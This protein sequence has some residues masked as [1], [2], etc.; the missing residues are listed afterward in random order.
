M[1][2]EAPSAR[3]RIG[4]ARR[5]VVGVGAT[6]A[7]AALGYAGSRRMIR[8][9][10]ARP[11]PERGEE[12]AERPGTERHVLSFDV[13][14]LVVNTVGPD[15]GPTLV[16]LHGFSG[17]LTL[18]HYQWKHFS[19]DYRCVLLDH[20]GHGRSGPATGGDYS[21]EA[22]GRDVKAVLDAEAGSGPVALVGHSLG[23]MAVLSFADQFPEEFGTRVR[24]VVLANTVA[25]DLVKAV[26]GGLGVHA[27]R[28]AAASAVRLASTPDRLYRIR[29]RALAGGGDL[30]FL[31]TRLTNFGPDAPPS[32][33]EYVASVGARAPVEVWT[34]L[35]GSLLQMDLGDALEK[36]SVPALVVVGDVDRLTPPSSAAALKRRLPE[37]RVVVLKGA[38]HCTMLERH[39]QFNRVVERF[40]RDA[41]G[42]EA[43]AVPAGAG[44][45]GRKR[46]GPQR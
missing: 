39:D 41:L 23:G 11:D 32:V 25:S 6:A 42:P 20:R 35:V 7:A 40:L 29:A 30:A 15:E 22:L 16:M 12:L 38:G 8:R 27:A 46:A 9:A 13:T 26:V 18:W 14:D 31:V 43:R 2:L 33:V 21:L 28:F 19:E 34:D 45:A 44:A 1:T 5:V 4:L 17:D 24:A 3:R 10:R 37:A 36:I